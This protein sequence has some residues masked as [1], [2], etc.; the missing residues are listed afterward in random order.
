MRKYRNARHAPDHGRLVW[1]A[2]F[3]AYRPNRAL[4]RYL[5]DMGAALDAWH[6]TRL[7]HARAVAKL[8]GR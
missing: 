8:L 2:E 6:Y 1:E 4:R 7:E 5:G 3:A